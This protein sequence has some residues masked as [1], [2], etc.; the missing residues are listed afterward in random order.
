MK[1]EVT[2]EISDPDSDRIVAF[3]KA[4]AGDT[5]DCD[6]AMLIQGATSLALF[7]EASMTLTD[8]AAAGAV[9]ADYAD[10]LAWDVFGFDVDAVDYTH[11]WRRVEEGANLWGEVSELCDGGLE[12]VYSGFDESGTFRLRSV[13]ASGYADP[14][15]VETLDDTDVLSPMDVRQ[16]DSI[17]R[18]IVH[19]Y[20]IYKHS[21]L[22]D[23]W[24]ARA[25]GIFTLIGWG[26]LNEVIA[27]GATWPAIGDAEF[28]AKYGQTEWKAPT[29]PDEK[30]AVKEAELTAWQKMWDWFI[31]FTHFELNEKTN[32]WEHHGGKD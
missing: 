8:A 2:R 30:P 7:R 19:G 23:F 25:T 13:L 18:L 17:N 11:P 20:Y 28:W 29:Q 14:S 27:N 1:Y 4:E 15:P 12:P 24:D 26:F 31:P 6:G 21:I 16:N 9:S 3:F 5:V 32:T 22:Y 10:T